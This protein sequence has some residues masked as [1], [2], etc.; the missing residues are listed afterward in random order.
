MN[1]FMG[2][3][4]HIA[5]KRELMLSAARSTKTLLRSLQITNLHSLKTFFLAF[6]S[7]QQYGLAMV[8][9]L[10]EDYNRAM[11]VFLQTVFCLPDSFPYLVVRG[12]LGIRPFEVTLLEARISF[13]R[14]GL[15]P[16]SRVRKVLGF[17][18]SVLTQSKVGVYT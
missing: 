18:S 2:V 15:N 12:L 17:Y 16:N 14:R 8:N 4:D 13:I 5:V 1:V 6:V 3:N 11:K 10:A 7:S 9:F